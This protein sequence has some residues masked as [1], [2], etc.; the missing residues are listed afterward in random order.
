VKKDNSSSTNKI[1]HSPPKGDNTLDIKKILQLLK[2]NWYLFVISFPLCYGVYYINQR[3]TQNIYKGSVTVL[4]KSDE[5]KSIS[6]SGLIE[7]FGLSPEM[8]SIENQ[9]IILRS[10]KMAKRAIDNLDFAIDIYSDGVF[11]DQDMYHTS[12][13][14][15]EMDS[16]HVQLLHTPIHIT[17]INEQTVTIKIETNNALL[18][19]FADE[20]NQ[21]GSGSIQFEKTINWGEELTT[22][23]CKFK[24][25]PKGSISLGKEI[26]YYFYFRSHDWLASTYR[27]K[28]GVSPYKEG[29]SILYISTT[30]TNTHKIINLL[31]ALCEVYLEENLER[32]NE[33]ASRTINFI[34]TQLKQVADT[35]AKAQEKLMEFKSGHLFIVPS[36]IS[37]RLA[38]QHFELDKELNLLKLKESYYQK[39]KVHIKENPLS[40]DYLLPAFS[41]DANNF[42]SSLVTELLSLSNELTLVKEQ[43]STDNPYIHEL[44]K[45]IQQG[46]SNLLSAIGQLLK[47]VSFEKANLH[48]QMK[49]L[50]VRI[51]KL[52]TIERNY[53]DIERTYKLNDAIYTF[54][55]QKQSETQITKA[56]NTPDNEIIDEASIVGIVSPNRSKSKQQA[57]L[58]ALALPIAIIALKEYF[59]NTIRS[60]D[61]IQ[62]FAPS[63]PIIGYISQYK[64]TDHNVIQAAPLSSISESFR[65]LRTKLNFMCTS[66]ATNIITLTSTNSGEGKTFCALNLASAYAISGK[67]TAL[68]GFD[69]RKPRLTEIFNHHNHT[70]L[71][72]YLIGQATIDEIQ[73][74]GYMDNLSIIPSGVI[75]PN[76]SELVANE[77]TDKLFKEL[78]EIYE[79]IIVDSPPLGVVADARILM[80]LGTCNLFV[81]RSNKTVRN[82]FKHT[83]HSLISE[84]V[85]HLTFILNDIPNNMGSYGYYSERYHTNI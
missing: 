60:K 54:L 72:N 69:L 66:S 50:A 39:L 81:I 41:L 1:Q 7:G 74:T 58:L 18:H 14:A 65:A 68:V 40:E 4:L 36:N 61:E 67:K 27:N 12:P 79:I 32:K 78:K 34:D 55:L 6:R 5:S 33:I 45:K 31:N 29:S 9:T 26:S 49:E 44:E 70:G 73:Y 84:N 71:S 10:Q 25:T 47:N 64:G 3:Y 76:P 43:S 38:D 42:I 57:L 30:G 35:L 24:I 48:S 23:F 11:K 51:D 46:K 20:T 52:P 85:P 80:D 62:N 82:H 75:P 13:F 16:T 21:G 37:S 22:P 53:L 2:S 15:I 63:I 17:P 59:N 28:I 56:S 19:S 83:V 77:Y 8:K